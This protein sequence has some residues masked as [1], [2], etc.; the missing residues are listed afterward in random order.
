MKL[1]NKDKYLIRRAL[2]CQ[3]ENLIFA[4]NDEN[5]GYH[6]DLKHIPEDD[7]AN[8]CYKIIGLYPA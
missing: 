2:F 4:I 5:S 6:E 7:F 8:Y 1:T 3:V